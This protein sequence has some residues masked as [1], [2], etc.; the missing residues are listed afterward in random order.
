MN[1]IILVRVS[2]IVKFILPDDDYPFV[3]SHVGAFLRRNNNK[4]LHLIYIWSKCVEYN[5]VTWMC[6]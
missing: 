6:L 3:Y 2:F 4:K 5:T 1:I